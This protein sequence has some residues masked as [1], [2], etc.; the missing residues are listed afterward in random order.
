MRKSALFFSAALMT[1]TFAAL[2]AEEVPPAIA[3]AKKSFKTAQSPL[4]RWGVK[5]DK[6]EGQGPMFKWSAS[7]CPTASDAPRFEGLPAALGE[8][9]HRNGGKMEM[10]E[11][12]CWQP[13]V[14]G[15]ATWFVFKFERLPPC[16]GN[17][18]LSGAGKAPAYQLQVYELHPSAV[19]TSGSDLEWASVGI[20]TDQ[21]VRSERNRTRQAMASVATLK[22]QQEK[23]RIAVELTRLKTKGTQVCKKQGE[24]TFLGFVEDVSGDRIKVLVTA[25]FWGDLR[26]GMRDNNYRG[27]EYIWSDAIEWRL[28]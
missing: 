7:T 25:H 24:G 27:Q 11:G 15:E 23:E 8:Y 6:V 9:C 28:C 3:F 20:K 14:G 22:E 16:G 4:M 17:V 26:T 5:G 2:G 21:Q 10:P 1:T 18:S 13:T 19:G 12:R